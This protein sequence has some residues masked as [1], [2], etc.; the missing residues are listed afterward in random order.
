MIRDQNEEKVE[1]S[2]QGDMIIDQD[3]S[4]MCIFQYLALNLQYHFALTDSMNSLSFYRF[5]PFALR[6]LSI[7]DLGTKYRMFGQTQGLYSKLKV[8]S[9]R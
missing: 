4:K 6:G 7:L 8:S 9:G 5:H 3:E 1:K 2:E